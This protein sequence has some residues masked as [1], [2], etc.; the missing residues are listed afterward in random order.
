MVSSFWAEDALK[1]TGTPDDGVL[2][3]AL[4]MENTVFNPFWGQDEEENIL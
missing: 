2:S 1:P 3:V 4:A